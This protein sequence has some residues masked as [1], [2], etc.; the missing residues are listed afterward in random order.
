VRSRAMELAAPPQVPGGLKFG[1]W[2]LLQQ[3]RDTSITVLKRNN[4]M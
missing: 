3:M 2:P 4:V 1:L